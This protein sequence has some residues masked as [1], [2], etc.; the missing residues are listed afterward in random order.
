MKT[1][2][3]Q[4]LLTNGIDESGNI[5]S[6]KTHRY[7]DSPIGKIP[8][9]WECMS[10]KDISQNITLKG[11]SN[12]TCINMDNIDSGIGLLIDLSD[13]DIKSDKNIFNK[14]DI[15]F[16]K[17]RPYLRKYYYV[18]FSG[19]CSSELMIFRSNSKI[20]S[21][22]LYYLIS[23]ERFIIYND[24]QTFGTRMPRTSWTIIK[25]YQIAVPGISEQNKILGIISSI[26]TKIKSEQAYLEKLKG[27]KRGLMQDLL[28]HTVKVDTLL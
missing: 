20:R 15:L 16:G 22:Y 23:S 17:L 3:M 8:V 9:E 26:D 25:D 27:I 24:S 11:K 12:T 19:F 4:D 14:D 5:R 21:K 13:S 10:F 18:D 28:T 1:G 6:P 2:L 7:K